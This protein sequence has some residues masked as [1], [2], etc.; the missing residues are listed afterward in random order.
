[1]WVLWAGGMGWG[2]CGLFSFVGVRGWGRGWEFCW[3]ILNAAEIGAGYGYPDSMG[4]TRQLNPPATN[5]GQNN[6]P[7]LHKKHRPLTVPTPP[8]QALPVHSPPLQR[9]HPP[10][11]EL[12]DPRRKL[13]GGRQHS[14]R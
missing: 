5:K 4:S 2:R 1:M 3:G 13:P 8:E 6:R 12:V 7:N 14:V 9:V 11:R 10:A